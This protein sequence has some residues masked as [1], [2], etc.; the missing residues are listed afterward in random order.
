MSVEGKF[1]VSSG[2]MTGSYRERTFDYEI[3]G[4]LKQDEYT[5]HDQKIR[6]DIEPSQLGEAEAVYVKVKGGTI[7][8]EEYRYVW[9]PFFDGETEIEHQ[10]EDFFVY[11]S[12]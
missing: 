6:E 2:R 12:G 4:W 11:G 1:T 10:L 5:P 9:G 3:V 7:D 8:G